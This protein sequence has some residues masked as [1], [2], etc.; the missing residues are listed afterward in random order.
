[1]HQ[2][3]LR[4]SGTFELLKMVKVFQA[5]IWN[6]LYSLRNSLENNELDQVQFF[7]CNHSLIKRNNGPYHIHSHIDR[8]CSSTYNS[9]TSRSNQRQWWNLGNRS[10]DT[11]KALGT[12]VPH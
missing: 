10:Q 1:M 3:L 6:Y 7:T 2:K 4:K 5:N 9:Q 8:F 11:L 12:Q